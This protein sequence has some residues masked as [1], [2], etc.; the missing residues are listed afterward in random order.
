M[1]A[2]QFLTTD[3]KHLIAVASAQFDAAQAGQDY[4]EEYID[5]TDSFQLENF[6]RDVYQRA[7]DYNDPQDDCPVDCDETDF[8]CEVLIASFVL[9]AIDYAIKNTV[10]T[11]TIEVKQF[12]SVLPKKRE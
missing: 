3:L 7:C 11:P 6:R 5:N 12:K 8:E 2:G 9:A 1:E 4:A 10:Q